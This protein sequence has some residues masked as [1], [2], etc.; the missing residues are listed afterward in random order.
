MNIRV[1]KD[2]LLFYLSYGIILVFSILSTSFY[3][4][5]FQGTLYKLVIV[6]CCVLLVCNELQKKINLKV[7]FGLLLCLMLFGVM[8]LMSAG[9]NQY[10]AAMV[11]LYIYCS[12]NMEFKKIARFTLYFDSVLLLFIIGSA[13]VGIIDNY[14]LVSQNR[15]REFLG[16]RYALYPSTFMFN[17]SALY[18]YLKKEKIR[19]VDYIILILLNLWLFIKTNSRVTFLL[20]CCL[21]LAAV[22]LKHKPNFFEKKR[23]LRG[24][25]VLSHVICAAVSVSLTMM[26][27]SSSHWMKALNS[28]LG[29]RLY[30]GH[31]SI[32]KNGIPLFGQRIEWTGN[33]LDAYGKKST[34]TY[35]WVDCFYIQVIQ[36][37]GILFFVILLVILT[38]A[39]VVFIKRKEWY[40]AVILTVV[41]LHCI[42]DDLSIYFFY[43]TFWIPIGTALLSSSKGFYHNRRRKVVLKLKR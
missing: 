2:D 16:F 17:I 3:Y 32:V 4:Q 14:V 34:D 11:I 6:F 24:L 26:Y 12:R 39:M 21:I 43:N 29:N 8:A 42:V 7:L 40:L 19:W 23:L 38:A 22:L 27:K 31:A 9:S 20:S 41:A 25:L 36:K 33:G 18:I 37:Y 1:K 10:V 35:D 30:L 28:A 13:Y 15:V 5:Y